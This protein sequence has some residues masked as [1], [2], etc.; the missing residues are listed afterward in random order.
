[1]KTLMEST[2]GVSILV[3][4]N[5]DRFLVPLLIVAA[6]FLAGL[7]LSHTMPIPG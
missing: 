5:T 4:L 6:L 3:K 1:M 7:V 2:R